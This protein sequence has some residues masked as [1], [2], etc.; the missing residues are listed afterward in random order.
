R[1]ARLLAHYARKSARNR[2]LYLSFVNLAFFGDEGDVFGNA[3][4]VLCGLADDAA[5]HRTLHALE[6]ARVNEPYPLRVVCDPIAEDS[7][8]WRPYMS[9]HRQ[10]FAWQYH[11]GGVWPFV[12]GFWVA[13]LA[14]AGRRGDAQREL[15]KLARANALD[16]WAFNEWLHGRTLAP[17]GM[18]GQSWNAAAFLIAQHELSA[19]TPLF[20]AALRHESPR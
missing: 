18:R 13:A 20:A 6:R 1:R 15:V 11:N 4:A 12:G 8:L 14:A 17:S 10:N 5:R 9:R 16:G 3:L 7:F 2:D 19:R